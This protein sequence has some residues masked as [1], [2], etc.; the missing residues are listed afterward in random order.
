MSIKLHQHKTVMQ[1]PFAVGPKKKACL[2][3]GDGPSW[4]KE[5]NR[6]RNNDFNL[7]IWLSVGALNYQLDNM[8]L[9]VMQQILN[10][11]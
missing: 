2:S 5:Q 10:D 1:I 3:R 11:T 7:F 4:R 9:Q 6:K 8:L